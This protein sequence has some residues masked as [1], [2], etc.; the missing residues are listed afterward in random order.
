MGRRRTE[1]ELRAALDTALRH[2]PIKA[3]EEWRVPIYVCGLIVLATAEG[4]NLATFE[5]HGRAKVERKIEALRRRLQ[6]VVAAVDALDERSIDALVGSGLLRAPLRRT[7][8]RA[9]VAARGADLSG[10]PFA[11]GRGRTA[12][13]RRAQVIADALGGAFAA[14]TGK[15]PAVRVHSYSS[16]EEEGKATYRAGQAYGPFLELVGAAFPAVGITRGAE[17]A[18][19]EACRN[20]KARQQRKAKPVRVPSKPIP[21]PI[22]AAADNT[23]ENRLA[24]LKAL[25]QLLAAHY[26]KHRGQA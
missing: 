21:V 7:A 11:R 6:A 2:L 15:R 18:A 23:P 26:A 20:F 12:E 16:E 22:M 4:R 1:V 10:G 13:G 19:R 3:G 8:L 17:A 9:I 25:K 5:R 14:L 24:N